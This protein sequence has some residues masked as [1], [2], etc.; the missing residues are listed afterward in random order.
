MSDV[1][2][3]S[4]R[5]DNFELLNLEEQQSKWRGSAGYWRRHTAEIADALAK[6]KKKYF[7]YIVKPGDSLKEGSWR[8]CTRAEYEAY[9]R[10]EHVG[11][12]TRVDHHHEKLEDAQVKWKTELPA[13]TEVPLLTN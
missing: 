10:Q 1:T 3:L 9:L 13:L 2:D 11:I 8:F 12:G 5:L 6:G 7:A 4:V